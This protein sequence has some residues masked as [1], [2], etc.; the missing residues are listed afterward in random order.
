MSI[1]EFISDILD[2]M[3]DLKSNANKK[4]YIVEE[5]EFELSFVAQK[6]IGGGANKL[7][8]L[9]IPVTVEANYSSDKIQKVKIKLKPKKE[10]KREELIQSN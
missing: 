2:E 6:T 4:K 5:L 7:W 1:K 9:F 3:Q 10:K 8:D